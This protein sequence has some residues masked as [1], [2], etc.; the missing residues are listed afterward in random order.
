MASNRNHPVPPGYWPAPQAYIFAAITLFIGMLVGYFL[1]GSGSSTPASTS[2]S[3]TTTSAGMPSSLSLPG[4]PAM[5]AANVGSL[6]SELQSRPNDPALLKQIGDAYYDSQQYQQAIEYYRRSLKIRPEDVNVRTD[7][8]TAMWYSGDPDGA[9]QQF[10]QSLKYQPNHA[11]TLFNMGVVKWQGKKD[12][13]GALQLWQRLLATN[14]DYPD[15]QKVEDMIQK[16]KSGA[17]M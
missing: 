13:Q 10:E 5:P 11:Q 15:R 16:V 12:P 7:M 3:T 9:I 6:L 4:G 1:R 14:P 17:T 2:S 8:G